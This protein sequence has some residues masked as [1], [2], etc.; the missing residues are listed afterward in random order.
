MT[1]P[2]VGV[3]TFAVKAQTTGETV[4]IPVHFAYG[5]WIDRVP[6]PDSV[7]LHAGAWA[8]PISQPAVSGLNGKSG[9][10]HVGADGSALRPRGRVAALAKD[11]MK[12]MEARWSAIEPAAFRNKNGT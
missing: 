9:D 11:A 4:W 6:Q 8:S 1:K 2:R 12:L 5:R 10:L 3:N 7:M